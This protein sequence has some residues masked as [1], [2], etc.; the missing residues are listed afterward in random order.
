MEKRISIMNGCLPEYGLMLIKC[1]FIST[2]LNCTVVHHYRV[3]YHMQ[4]QCSLHTHT[5]TKWLFI[6]YRVAYHM[7]IRVIYI[8]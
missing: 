8:D 1:L 6:S 5:H 7:D 2:K 3:G 4:I